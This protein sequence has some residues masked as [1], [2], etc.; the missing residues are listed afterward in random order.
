MSDPNTA[1]LSSMAEALGDLC[2]QVVFVGVC[3]T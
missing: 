3:A 1:L 2:E